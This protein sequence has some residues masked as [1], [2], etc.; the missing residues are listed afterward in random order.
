MDQTLQ[1][2]VQRLEDQLR[3]VLQPVSKPRLIMTSVASGQ[4]FFVTPVGG[5][6]AAT[7]SSGTYTPGSAVCDRHEWSGTDIVDAGTTETVYNIS[8]QAIAASVLIKAAQ[9]EDKWVVD[10]AGCGS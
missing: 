8:D 3:Q 5:I 7:E 2:R 6:A 1:L 10:V 9:V 4:A